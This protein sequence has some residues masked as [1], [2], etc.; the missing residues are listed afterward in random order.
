[1]ARVWRLVIR[2]PSKIIKIKLK[3]NKKFILPK[4]DKQTIAVDK[5]CDKFLNNPSKKCNPDPIL[6][7]E[8][9][10]PWG[11]GGGVAGIN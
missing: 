4:R 2:S 1:M 8:P 5:N 3:C 10:C 11:G 6:F 7:P 9:K